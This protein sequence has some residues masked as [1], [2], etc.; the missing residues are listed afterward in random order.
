MLSTEKKAKRFTLSTTL[1]ILLISL[2]LYL[3]HKELGQFH[4][5]ELWDSVVHTPSRRLV[6]ALLLTVISFF[7]LSLFE[8]AALQYAGRTLKRKKVF[9]SSAISNAFSNLVGHPAISG[10]SMRYRFYSSWGLTPVEI[11]KTTAFGFLTAT[12]GMLTLAGGLFLIFPQTIPPAFSIK[13]LSSTKPI[14]AILCLLTFI[15]MMLVVWLRKPLK[16]G[17][18]SLDLPNARFSLLQIMMGV[19]DWTLAAAVF[20]ALIPADSGLGFGLVL[21][22][23]LFSQIAGIL[24][25][26]PGGLGVFEA[27]ALAFLAPAL[28][29]HALVSI[30]IVYRGVYYLLPLLIALI[31]LGIYELR[32]IRKSAR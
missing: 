7:M 28:G 32:Q 10:G 25:H 20:Y 9:L 17:K 19:M 31:V 14:G 3:L 13:A 18:W 30:L 5:Q 2:I 6:P 12:L 26:L 22:V 29:T 15:Y 8:F 1:K 21:S 27:V 11:A 23:F 24:S 16:I 4:Y